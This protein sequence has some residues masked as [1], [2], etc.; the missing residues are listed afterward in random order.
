MCFT[1]VLPLWLLSAKSKYSTLSGYDMIDS[2][3][4]VPSK[5]AL[6]FH[7]IKSQMCFRRFSHLNSPH[8]ISP[9]KPRT[10]ENETSST[11]FFLYLIDFILFWHAAVVFRSTHLMPILPRP[12]TPCSLSSRTNPPRQIRYLSNQHNINPRY[13]DNI[14]I[15]N[16]FIS[17]DSSEVDD[18]REGMF[19]PPLKLL[20]RNKGLKWF[21]LFLQHKEVFI[22]NKVK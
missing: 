22:K 1:A 3:S 2:R 16:H 21:E 6:L 19:L 9:S 17:P 15:K 10:W 18:W 14:L 5:E 7:V 13:S 8:K 12:R 11:T 4:T 20:Q